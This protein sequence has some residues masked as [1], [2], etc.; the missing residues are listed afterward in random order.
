M[1][2]PANFKQIQNIHARAFTLIELL[3][4]ISIVATLLAIAVPSFREFVSG[5]RIKTASY[6]IFYTLTYMRSEAIKRNNDVT[7]TPATG[8]WQNGWTV[9]VGT[10][11][12]SQHEA[13]PGLTITGPA[14]NLI[15]SGNGHLKT[16]VNPF[17][18]SSSASTSLAP[19][20]VSIN[21]SGLPN[22]KTGSC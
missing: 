9:T 1:C 5:Q 4:T 18:I 17:G 12:L 19:R 10:T 21:L 3:V 7:L 22:S 11:T 8:G 16:A 15:Y 2:N 14:N 20:C 13:F 6:D